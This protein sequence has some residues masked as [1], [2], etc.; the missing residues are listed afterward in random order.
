MTF[1]FLQRFIRFARDGVTSEASP[2]LVVLHLPAASLSSALACR[3]SATA[4]C[5]SCC[6]PTHWLPSIPGCRTRRRRCSSCGYFPVVCPPR[7]AKVS[8]INKG[9]KN[10]NEKAEECA[11]QLIDQK[12]V[13]PSWS[14]GTKVSSINK[15]GKNANK[16]AEECAEQ[17][18][19]QKQ[20]LPS[21]SSSLLLQWYQQ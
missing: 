4:R 16:K 18:E 2:G 13:V 6:R 15:G 14:S 19:D 17:L 12:K 1:R 9:G 10:A 3:S 8:P 21:W 5:Q 11:E 20:V 7:G